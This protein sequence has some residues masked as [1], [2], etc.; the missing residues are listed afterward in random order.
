[1]QFR[2]CWLK[3]TFAK[4]IL[5]KWFTYRTVALVLQELTI[6]STVTIQRDIYAVVIVAII[7]AL[8]AFCTRRKHKTRMLFEPSN[9]ST[10][11][12][13]K[14]RFHRGRMKSQP[15]PEKGNRKAKHNILRAR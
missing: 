1:M 12:H 11:E 6:E 2:E 10:H 4:F 9:P 15:A 13:A 8:R 5:K 14:Q 7:L 3:R